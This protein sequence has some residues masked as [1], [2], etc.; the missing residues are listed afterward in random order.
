MGHTAGE[1]E[2]TGAYL[3]ADPGSPQ[4]CPSVSPPVPVPTMS[5]PGAWHIVGAPEVKWE[6]CADL[7]SGALYLGMCVVCTWVSFFL[8]PSLPAGQ[9]L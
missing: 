7:D 8:A 3:G 6:L 9:E 1:G 2:S 5:W 4:E